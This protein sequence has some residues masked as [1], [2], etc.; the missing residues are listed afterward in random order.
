MDDY[1]D[2][3]EWGAIVYEESSK[4]KELRGAPVKT[5]GATF[6]LTGIFDMVLLLA[7]YFITIP[8]IPEMVLNIIL[9]ILIISGVVAFIMAAVHLSRTPKKIIILQNGMV[10]GKFKHFDNMPT[11]EIRGP[12][13]RIVVLSKKM[14]GPMY[15]DADDVKRKKTYSAV[16][17]APSEFDFGEFKDALIKVGYNGEGPELKVKKDDKE[18]GPPKDDT[19]DDDTPSKE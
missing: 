13:D 18:D 7:L 14:P 11:I 1:Y 3:E 9:A 5:K 19:S 10:I 6:L 2:S 8:A 12:R 4:N 16:L 17:E 15:A